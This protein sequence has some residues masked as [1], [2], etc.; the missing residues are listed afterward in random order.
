ML[1]QRTKLD[2]FSF[3]HLILALSSM[4]IITHQL[5]VRMQVSA[6]FL[7]LLSIGVACLL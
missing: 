1:D 4:A 7:I 5:F 2:L 3:F 6:T